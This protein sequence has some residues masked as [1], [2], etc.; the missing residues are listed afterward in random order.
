VKEFSKP[1]EIEKK[2]KEEKLQLFIEWIRKHPGRKVKFYCEK[3]VLSK[4]RLYRICRELR[5]TTPGALVKELSKTM[6]KKKNF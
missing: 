4:T 5:N 2:K 6:R 3:M 1:Y